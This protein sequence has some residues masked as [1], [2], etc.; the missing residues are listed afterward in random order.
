MLKRIILSVLAALALTTACANAQSSHPNENLV[1]WQQGLEP[2]SLDPARYAQYAPQQ[3]ANRQFQNC[4]QPK[5]EN[6]ERDTIVVSHC[7]LKLYYFDEQGVTHVFNISA[8][9]DG[10]RWS[11]VGYVGM[12]AEWPDWYPPQTMLKRQPELLKH[13]TNLKGGLGMPGGVGN[14][15]GARALYIFDAK[16]KAVTE[17]RIHGTADPKSIGQWMSS[18][19]FRLLNK[20]ILSL[21]EKV[22]VG[23]RVV[24]LN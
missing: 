17:Y 24:V 3:K 22:R 6:Y 20:D 1:R 19:C 23:T 8:G 15:L 13:L 14:P 4:V 18:G 5:A 2:L 7:Q 10:F 11:G 16:T 21:Y 12:K 9:R